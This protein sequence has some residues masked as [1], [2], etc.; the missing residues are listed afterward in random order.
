M[1]AMKEPNLA[2]FIFNATLG[3]LLAG[4]IM[5]AEHLAPLSFPVVACALILATVVVRTRITYPVRFSIRS[6]LI[7]TTF[8]AIALGMLAWW[9]G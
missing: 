9:D 3:L 5:F 4:T 1:C 6:L 2:R 8:I 7:A